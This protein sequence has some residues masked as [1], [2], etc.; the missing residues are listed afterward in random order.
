MHTTP[1]VLIVDDDRLV[2]R[3]LADEMHKLNCKVVAFAS[4]G[5]EAVKHF[6][7]HKPD[8]TML[9][10]LM[11][12]IHGVKVLKQIRN[13]NNEAFICMVSATA[14]ADV[15]RK[16]MPLG[17]SAFVVKPV[18]PEKLGLAVEMFRERQVKRSPQKREEAPAE[19]AGK[20]LLPVDE[21]KKAMVAAGEPKCDLPIAPVKAVAP[22]PSRVEL[23]AAVK[24]ETSPPEVKVPSATPEPKTEAVVVKSQSVERGKVEEKAE[25]VPKPVARPAVEKPKSASKPA[26]QSPKPSSVVKK[27]SFQ[28]SPDELAQAR[29]M[30]ATARFQEMPEVFTLLQEE[31]Q[32]EDPDFDRVIGRISSDSELSRAFLKLVNTAASGLRQQVTSVS[33]CIVMVGQNNLKKLLLAMAVRSSF[34]KE[35]PFAQTLWGQATAT[36]VAAEKLSRS[37][38][39]V[40]AEEAFLAGLFQDIGALIC[41]QRVARYPQLYRQS[42]PVAASLIDA[43]RKIFKTHHMVISHLLAK[44]WDLS[45]RSCDAILL[46]HSGDLAGYNG[47]ESPSFRALVS[48]LKISNYLVGA[49]THPEAEIEADVEQA[50][51]LAVEELQLSSNQISGVKRAISHALKKSAPDPEPEEG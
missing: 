35:S 51:T 45:M 30:V 40:S 37:I 20:A 4:D 32:K 38:E 33:Q 43:D 6:Q 36:A 44:Q 50:Y 46:S 11:P 7:Q 12:R 19:S 15:V 22:E 25:D 39:A 14:S 28:P 26:Q 34:G 3:L 29:K 17:V 41:A 27:R 1:T 10:I 2:R 49:R 42:H 8:I 24:S 18:D 48:V 5:V 47:L 23:P 31:L 9:D 21:S 13:L 16:L